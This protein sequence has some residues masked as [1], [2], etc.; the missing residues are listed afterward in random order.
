MSGFVETLL[1]RLDDQLLE[2]SQQAL[3][4]P[5]ERDAFAFGRACGIYAGLDRARGILKEMISEADDFD[6]RL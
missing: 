1:K 2:H 3:M 4:T 6:D 5:G